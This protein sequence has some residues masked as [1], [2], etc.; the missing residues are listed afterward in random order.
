M[1][2]D[3]CGGLAG[4][5]TLVCL[6]VG[7]GWRGSAP[8]RLAC[9][10]QGRLPRPS[11]AFPQSILGAKRSSSQHF[12]PS[13]TDRPRQ[14]AGACSNA[15]RRRPGALPARLHAQARLACT[16]AGRGGLEEQD[17]PRQ[18]SLPKGRAISLARLADLASPPWRGKTGARLHSLMACRCATPGCR[19][20][21]LCRVKLAGR[22]GLWPLRICPCS[23]LPL[24]APASPCT[25]FSGLSRPPGSRR[26]SQA[27]DRQG[28]RTTSLPLPCPFPAPAPRPAPALPAPQPS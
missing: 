5:Q 22:H 27:P 7:E 12:P 19:R 4:R 25:A 16:P 10:R 20:A 18:T 24:D 26:S 14:T 9:R 1:I 21:G 23:L 8:G 11:R 2:L 6:P 13:L 17:R 28:R 3:A 15:S